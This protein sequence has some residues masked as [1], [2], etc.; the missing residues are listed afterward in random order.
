MQLPPE[1]P[2][3]LQ[4]GDMVNVSLIIHTSYKWAT[5]QE[6]RQLLELQDGPRMSYEVI[7]KAEDWIIAGRVRGEFQ[8]RESTMVNIPLT[9]VPIRGGG[10]LFLPMVHIRPIP[11]RSSTAESASDGAQTPVRIE[12]DGPASSELAYSCETFYE[13]AAMSFAVVDGSTTKATAKI[14]PAPRWLV[15]AQ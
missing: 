8:A 5:F 10:R 14:D 9:L 3:P 12:D 15:S 6:R 1:I 11:S 2:S 4:Y 7:G 13:N